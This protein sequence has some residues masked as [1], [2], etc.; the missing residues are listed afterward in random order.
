MSADTQILITLRE[1]C[2]AL[3][4]RT[5][6]LSTQHYD[7]VDQCQRDLTRLDALAVEIARR[8]QVLRA[9]ARG[10]Q[11]IMA[12][13]TQSEAITDGESYAKWYRR[14]IQGYHTNSYLAVRGMAQA[15]QYTAQQFANTRRTI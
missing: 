14:H 7:D 3:E 8:Q 9:W 13:L 2:R 1:Y 12:A 5:D 15:Q 10:E 11:P 6:I 4:Q